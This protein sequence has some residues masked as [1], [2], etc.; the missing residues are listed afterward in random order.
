MCLSCKRVYKSDELVEWQIITFFVTILRFIVYLFRNDEKDHYFYVFNAIEL[1]TW[2][3]TTK[4]AV[5]N[6]EHSSYF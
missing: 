1:R 4:F 2:P 5:F 6:R 3:F